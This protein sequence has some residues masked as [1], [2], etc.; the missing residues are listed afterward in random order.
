MESLFKFVYITFYIPL[1]VTFLMIS[2]YFF[3]I[4]H[5]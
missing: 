1:P 4:T 3:W 2:Y 5:E